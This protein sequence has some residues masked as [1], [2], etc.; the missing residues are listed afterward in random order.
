M[1]AI[2]TLLEAAWL[3]PVEPH[4]Q[5]LEQHAV[6]IDQGQIIAIRPIAAARAEFAAR[7]RVDLGRHLLI[8][9]LVNAH[10]HAAMSLMR[11]LADDLPLMTWLQQHIWPAEGAL[12]SPEFVA[13]GVELATAEML[14][15]GTTCANDMYFFPEVAAEV[16]ARLGMRA[17]LGLIVME[18]P[19]PYARDPD[20][21]FRKGTALADQLRGHPSIQTCFAPH[22][23]Y[24]VS[25]ASFKRVRT[26]AD[27]MGLRI[28]CH[29][30]ETAFEVDEGRRRHGERPL[31]RLKRMGLLGDD[32][33]AVHMTQLDA[34][35]IELCAR[36]GLSVAHCPESNLKLASGFAPVQ[37]L[38]QAGVNVAI[39]TD[40]AA[41]NNDL[42]ML[43]EMRSAALLAKAVSGN[44]AAMDA[45]TALRCAT[46]GGAKALGLDDRIGSIEVGKRADLVALRC[47]SLD[48][49]PL[50]QPTS[51][52]VYCASR[53][54]VSDVWVDGQRR[55]REG[56]VLGVDADDLAQRAR[57]WGLR[58]RQ[59][60]AK[61]G[62]SPP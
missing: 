18:F 26:Y 9:G 48:Q 17:C 33:I 10:T 43:G 15:G 49:L 47:D 29:I 6:A 41:S 22:A 8:P 45:A 40:G 53:R 5:V 35:E 39:G 1:R 34:S 52:L 23:P 32:L 7:E 46:L 14:R 3:I 21:Y 25:D 30:H 59:A 24:T 44:A 16:Y 37:S 27:Q 62:S 2:D 57:R 50:Y 13:D 20:E 51:H 36:M 12:V 11:G 38:L 60:V 19:T 28:H 54:D 42:D 58:V 55:V 4:A 31:A 61:A 56:I